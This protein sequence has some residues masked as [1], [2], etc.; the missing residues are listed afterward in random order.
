M[1]IVITNIGQLVTPVENV[2]GGD[3]HTCGLQT[4]SNASLCIRNGR[5]V[6]DHPP[7]GAKQVRTIDAGGCVAI[8]GLIDPF[9]VMPRLPTWMDEV[10]ESKLPG[11]DLLS[12][13]LRL[14]QR[15]LRTGV[16]T[17]EVKCPHD[18][19]FTGLEALGHL[20]QH[21][22]PRVVGT[23]LASLPE[24]SEDRDRSMSTLIG[25]VIPEI[26]RRRLATFCDVGWG[27]R[28]GYITEARTVLRAASGAGLRPKL[29]IQAPSLAEDVRD[30]ALSLEVAAIGCAS[31]LPSV[32]AKHLS[33]GNVSP[34]YL[35]I[36]PGGQAGQHL[37]V[38]ALL[39]QGVRI[40]IG[41]GNGLLGSTSRSMWA[42]LTS[43]VNLMGMSLPEAICACT[44]NN[45]MALEMSHEVGS[46]EPGKRAD[47]V[48]LDLVDFREL[49]TV[50]DSPPVSMV[51]V[52]GEIVYSL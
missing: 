34:V 27:S 33:E 11:N 7:Q 16:T 15:A 31:H 4:T 20:T 51:M 47:L 38:R 52:N 24:C 50:V 1:D 42:V 41:S 6:D 49:E 19:E 23:L 8:P 44:L 26:R 48:L 18:S 10:P 36:V 13:S 25:D 22:Q 17:V 5:I 35:P 28:S 46:L 3:G 12:W 37:H 21:H 45:A 14:L 32:T 9:W 39:D 30:L 40:A 2:L 43:A 29:H